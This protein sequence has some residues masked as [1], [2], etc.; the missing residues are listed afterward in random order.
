[1]ENSYD[2]LGKIVLYENGELTHAE[3]VELFQHL[4]DT[5]LAWQLQGAYGRRAQALIDSQEILR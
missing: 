4:I 5:G 3:E 2:T 1:M